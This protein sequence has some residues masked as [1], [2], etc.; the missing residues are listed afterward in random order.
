MPLFPT[1]GSG[2][3]HAGFCFRRSNGGGG[4]TQ[5]QHLITGFLIKANSTFLK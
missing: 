2:S 3:D 5:T 1:R 4:D